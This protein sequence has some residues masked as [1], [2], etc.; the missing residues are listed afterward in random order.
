MQK[1]CHFPPV[2]DI[3]GVWKICVY[4]EVSEIWLFRSIIPKD[5]DHAEIL[6]QN[7]FRAIFKN[8]KEV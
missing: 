4:R 1:T 2:F 7:D 8:E 5:N 3:Q 6:A